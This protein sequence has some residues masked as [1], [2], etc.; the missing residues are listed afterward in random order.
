[1]ALSWNSYIRRRDIDVLKLIQQH[2]IDS[3]ETLCD[4]LTP[5]GVN[6]P[7]RQLTEDWGWYG[8]AAVIKVHNATEH[9][10]ATK[11]REPIQQEVRDL[12]ELQESRDNE[13]KK[14]PPAWKRKK[15]TKK[16]AKKPS[17]KASPKK[18]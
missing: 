2:R 10:A 5:K 4:F 12:L 9:I 3:Y 11:E 7:D 18:A 15:S 17:K 16:P 6:P 13:K 8:G 14:A 1:M